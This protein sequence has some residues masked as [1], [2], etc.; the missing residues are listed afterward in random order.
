[1]ATSEQAIKGFA[2]METRE[3]QHF[4]LIGLYAGFNIRLLRALNPLESQK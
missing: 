2:G 4:A 3:T 1:M